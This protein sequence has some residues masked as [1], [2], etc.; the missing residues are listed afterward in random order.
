[1]ARRKSYSNFRKLD[2]YRPAHVDGQT[3]FKVFQCLNPDCTEMIT[4]RQD[5]INED[6]SVLCPKCGYELH[7]GGEQ[8]LFDFSMDVNNGDE[9][10]VS[11]QEGEF[12]VSHDDYI[13]NAPLY[14]YCLLCNTLKPIEFFHKHSSL[15]SGRQG[16]CISCKTNYNAVKNGT[17][18]P[19]Q[20]F[21]SSQ[22]RRLLIEVAGPARVSRKT[23]EQ[24]YDHKCFN[25]GADLSKVKKNKEKPI[26]HT[27][28]VYYLWPATTDSGTL[29]CYKC[30]GNK[31]GKWPSEYYSDA[32]LHELAVYTGFDYRLLAGPPVYNPDALRRL[33]EPAAVDALLEKNAA[34]MEDVCKL[35]N[36][37]LADTSIDFFQ[38][39]T[40]LSAS[41]ITYADSI[42]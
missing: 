28:P 17:R 24:K 7:S 19:D 10:P 42:K 16:E 34:H 23:I 2:Q 13:E 8:H 1:M 12:V 31:T 41:W 22:K 4:V 36:R 11:V 15:S 30:N 32:K 40:H 9:I 26:D 29:L 39:A 38:F 3:L 20:H 25:C 5:D 14:K 35:R 21:E 18:I 37:I 27:L 33:Q 6:Y